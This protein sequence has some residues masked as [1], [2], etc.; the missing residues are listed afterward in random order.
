M[1]T[2]NSIVDVRVNVAPVSTSGTGFSTGLILAPASGSSVTETQRLRL[3]ASAADLLADPSGDFTAASPA[4][5]AAKSYFTADPAPDRVYVSLYPPFESLPDALDAVLNL[6]ADFYGVYAAEPDSVSAS[7]AL[8][9]SNTAHQDGELVRMVSM[10]SS[11][12]YGAKPTLKLPA[13][14]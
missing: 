11:N 8:S 10:P 7:S 13:S 9:L 12:A 1:L 6:S 5:L 14:A 4:Y 2:L 3:F